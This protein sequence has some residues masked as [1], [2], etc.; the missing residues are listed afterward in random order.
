MPLAPPDVVII[1]GPNG[2]GKSTLTQILPDQGIVIPPAYINPDDIAR[3]LGQTLP[4]LSQ[5]ERNREAFHQARQLRQEYREEGIPFAFETVFSHPSGLLDMQRL[6]SAGYIVT[7]VV[8]TTGSAEINVRRVAERVRTGG[9]SVDEDKIRERH[10]RFLRLL[11]RI[12]EEADRAFV[13][14]ASDIIRLCY[15]TG[16]RSIAT[17]EMP[18]YLRQRLLVPLEE[19]EGA[20]QEVNRMLMPG[21]ALATP[22]EEKGRYTGVIRAC[23]PFY[24]IQEVGPQQL[25]RHDALLLDSDVAKAE[26]I[27]IGYQSGYGLIEQS[28]P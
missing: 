7:L 10:G 28:T 1:A 5:E 9:H 19:R 11:P 3:Q 18:D 8:V 25:V 20:R 21:E 6:R 16:R 24:A 4:E 13:F 27:S 22:D 23:V 17:S 14:D 12:V 2:S 26:T 15:R